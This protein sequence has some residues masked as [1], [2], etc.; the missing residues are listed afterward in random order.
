LYNNSFN[1]FYT[2]DE[3]RVA[4]FVIENEKLKAKVVN[5][6]CHNDHKASYLFMEKVYNYISHLLDL[7]P[8]AFVIMGGDFNACMSANDSLN[9]VKTKKE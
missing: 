8:H 6:C 9:R 3:C 2:D 1:V 7:H 5:V 4:V